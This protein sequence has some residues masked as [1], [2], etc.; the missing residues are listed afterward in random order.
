V[1]N[2]HHPG[3]YPTDAHPVRPGTSA[4]L[5]A[6]TIDATVHRPLVRAQETAASLVPRVAQSAAT[7]A[8]PVFLASVALTLF[9]ILVARRMRYRPSAIVVGALLI[10]TL[11]SFNPMQPPEPP[12]MA[13][14]RTPRTLSH[15][16]SIARGRQLYGGDM[17]D[18]GDMSEQMPEVAYAPQPPD[19]PE[20][21]EADPPQFIDIPDYGIQIQ[22]PNDVMEQVPQVSRRWMRS[23]ERMMREN[24]ELRELMEQLRMRVREEARRERWRRLAAKRHVRPEEIESIGYVEVP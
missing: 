2:P 12:Q 14:L 22:V 15:D 1:T 19:V 21:P 3:N 6:R 10:V 9:F 18:G 8:N 5:T 4:A 17:N 23:A 11:S 7:I 13:R 20:T 16:A 24:Q